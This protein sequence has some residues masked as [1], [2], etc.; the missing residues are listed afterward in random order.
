VIHFEGQE[1]FSQELTAISGFL[2]DAGQ[3]AKTL[4]EAEVIDA[5]ADRATWKV[6]PKFA[7][8]A[9]SLET[10][11]EVISRTETKV[12]YRLSSK[13]VGSGSVVE[14]ELH[15]STTESGTQVN[16][17]G[18]LTELGGLLKLVPK[19][20]IQAAAQKV[21]ADVWQAIHVKFAENSVR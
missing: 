19:G 3:L 9:G 10:V 14:A 18:N 8:M 20:L 5:T 17:V 15:F 7:F 12:Q 16:W 4:P 1:L 6:R 2:G 11:A 21:I 13:G